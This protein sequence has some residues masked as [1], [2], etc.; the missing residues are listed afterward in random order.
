VVVDAPNTAFA[1]L[2]YK[3]LQEKGL[4][5]GDYQV[6]PVG[7]TNARLQAMTTDPSAVAGMLS[8]PQNVMGQ[9]A[10]LKNMGTA[11]S[12]VGPYQSDAGWVLR[13]WGTANADTL[14]RYIQANVEGIR[15]AMN[16]ANRAALVTMLAERFKLAPD[17]IADILRSTVDQQ[18]FAVDAGFDM[19]GFENTLKLRADMLGTWGGNPPPPASK[20]LD[21][22]YYQR[23]IAGL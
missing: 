13:S 22:S 14:V 15:W 10:G 19:K 9:R 16:P 11:V 5:R 3:M 23:A 17:V 20:Y 21:L 18:G 12:V 1:L 7:G 6:K 8:P 2:L 4:K